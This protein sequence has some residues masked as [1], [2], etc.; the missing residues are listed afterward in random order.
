MADMECGIG[1]TSVPQRHSFRLH[2]HTW[3]PWSFDS[4]YTTNTLQG[5]EVLMVTQTSDPH[6][7]LAASWRWKRGLSPKPFEG[8]ARGLQETPLCNGVHHNV[9]FRCTSVESSDR[10]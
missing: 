3:F 8:L 2:A 5:K 9:P 4:Y 6:P 7:S 10:V 1:P